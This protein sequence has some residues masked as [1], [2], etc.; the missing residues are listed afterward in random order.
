MQNVHVQPTLVSGH[1][2]KTFPLD[3]PPDISTITIP[4]DIL[5]LC[6]SVTQYVGSNNSYSYQSNFY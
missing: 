6:W 4:S 3:I 5:R 2:P 1:P